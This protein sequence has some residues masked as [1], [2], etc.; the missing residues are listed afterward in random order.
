MADE[1]RPALV[2]SDAERERGI[3]L[4]RDAVVEAR[5]TLEEFNG[6]EEADRDDSREAGALALL[7]AFATL[8]RRNR[9]T[10]GL[11]GIPSAGQGRASEAPSVIGCRRSVLRCRTW[12]SA[13]G[14]FATGPV[15]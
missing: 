10:L 7:D 15:R 3:S 9:S 12:R 5:L 11:E 13:Y 6:L 1:P 14:T 8:G 4:R 2:V